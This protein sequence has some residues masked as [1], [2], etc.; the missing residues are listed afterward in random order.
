MLRK[1]YFSASPHNVS[2]F[3]NSKKIL[4]EC[5]FDGLDLKLHKLYDN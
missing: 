5:I 4:D 3:L 2:P 1:K